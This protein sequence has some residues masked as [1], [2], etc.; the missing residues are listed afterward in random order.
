M[1]FSLVR[2]FAKR[3]N[4][5]GL[6]RFAKNRTNEKRANLAPNGVLQLPL[7][8]KSEKAGHRVMESVVL[9]LTKQLK[10]KVNQQKSAM[11]RPWKRKFLGFTFTESKGSNRIVI[12][13]SRIKRF[14][15]K[16][17]GLTKKMRGSEMKE[18]IRKK[19]MPIVRG[20]TN[21][22][23][24]AGCRTTWNL[25]GWIRRKIRGIFWRQWKKPY[26]RYKRLIALGL[27]ENTARK[28]AYSSKG[29]WHMA[30]SYGMHKALSNEMIEKM[31]YIP[32]Q[33]IML[34]RSQ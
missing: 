5:M 14:K 10:L 13:E 7:Y 22:F 12:H 29:P 3:H 26:T 8:V 16:I 15:D 28:T 2:F 4:L 32:I 6:R 23:C 18:N 9:Y 25:D 30:K 11:D 24:I 33:T 20:W 21:Y 27:K 19:I 1:I 34:A 17:R 31:G